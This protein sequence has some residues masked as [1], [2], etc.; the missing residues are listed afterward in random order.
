[1]SEDSQGRKRRREGPEETR[2]L[3]RE[4]RKKKEVRKEE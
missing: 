4:G 1:V 2:G 3:E